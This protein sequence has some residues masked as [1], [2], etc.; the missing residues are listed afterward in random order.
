MPSQHFLNSRLQS[1]KKWLF[2][3]TIIIC[4]D[5]LGSPTKQNALYEIMQQIKICAQKCRQLLQSR[6]QNLLHLIM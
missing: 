2:L 6:K 5:G 3:K 1:G 4:V